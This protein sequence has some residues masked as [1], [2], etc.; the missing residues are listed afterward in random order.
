VNLSKWLV[1]SVMAVALPGCLVAL[2]S[3]PSAHATPT[4]WTEVAYFDNAAH[5][6]LVGEGY[7]NCNSWFVHLWWGV[8]TQYAQITNSGSCEW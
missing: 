8:K 3:T 5:T 4:E 1:L 7:T 6:T 2:S